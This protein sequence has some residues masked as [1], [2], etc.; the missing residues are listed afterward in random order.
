MNTRT[1]LFPLLGL[2]AC[3][4]NNAS[5]PDARAVMPDSR[6]GDARPLDATITDDATLADDATLQAMTVQ[7]YLFGDAA[8]N[9][10]IPVRFEPAV[11]DAIDTVT[12][13]TGFA[14][15][16]APS[17]TT[18]T[19][20]KEFPGPQ[21]S[22]YQLFS[23]RGANP[24]D[25]YILGAPPVTL[26]TYNF[27]IALTSVNAADVEIHTP[28]GGS[29]IPAGTT[30]ETFNGE[31]CATPF[32]I[33]ALTRD[34]NTSAVTTWASLVD[35]T[36]VSEMT[37]LVPSEFAAPS[38][39]TASVTNVPAVYR[40]VAIHLNQ[41]SAGIDINDE[42]APGILP[43]E[44]HAAS[45]SLA[46][47]PVADQAVRVSLNSADSKHKRD[48][49]FN[50]VPAT[51]SIDYNSNSFPVIDEPT[52]NGSTRALSWTEEPVVGTA[53]TIDGLLVE[54]R[55]QVPDG[56]N[57]DAVGWVVLTPPGAIGFTWPTAPAPLETADIA[58]STNVGLTVIDVAA[59]PALSF[60]DLVEN[61]AR[62]AASGHA[63]I[64]GDVWFT[65]GASN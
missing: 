58:A 59:Q 18:I 38:T 24:G 57:T 10:G 35:Q 52:I 26:P 51:T 36:P 34:V 17:G 12:D 5:L 49:N 47:A 54:S 39:M 43:D 65:S 46:F 16:I 60:H 27:A 21:G 20:G 42:D 33:L 9:A 55:Y 30:T 19:I 15:A 50:A 31:P 44:S 3:S 56:N 53:A 23:V 4:N 63:R 7:L 11:G 25:A 32:D 62:S 48:V 29:P 37:Y 64:P 2:I 61:F 8:A 45:V 22:T 1:L 28:C 14:S 6:S 40:D 41:Y 13:S